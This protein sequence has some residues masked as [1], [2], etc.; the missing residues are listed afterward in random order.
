M[1]FILQL[2]VPAILVSGKNAR[3]IGGTEVQ[4]T[5][6][7]PWIVAIFPKK[8][9]LRNHCGG[10]IIDQ[11]WILT[12]AHCMFKVNATTGMV[13]GYLQANEISILAGTYNL[14]NMDMGLLRNV[15]S[16]HMHENWDTST[17]QHDIALLKLEK[18]LSLNDSVA[19]ISLAKKN[20]P[21]NPGQMYTAAGWGATW[22]NY[23][24]GWSEAQHFQPILKTVDVAEV[25]LNRCMSILEHNEVMQRLFDESNETVEIHDTQIC[26]GDVEGENVCHGDS[27]GPLSMTVNSTDILYGIVSW[28]MLPCGRGG[29]VVYTYVAIYQEWITRITRSS[30]TAS[31]IIVYV[32]LGLVAG[33]VC[34]GLIILRRHTAVGRQKKTAEHMTQNAENLSGSL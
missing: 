12:A 28:G 4:D 1:I 10:S 29:P 8:H 27:G 19:K 33:I 25:S 5:T 15:S 26:A 14:S 16:V 30:N 34:F 6:T 18:P 17:Y 9:V 2:I 20:D 22:V 31:N 23:T 11:S 13:D 7:F 3:V 21:R 24:T 32:V